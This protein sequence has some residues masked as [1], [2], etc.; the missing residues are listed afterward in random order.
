VRWLIVFAA[1]L[2]AALG[3]A[4]WTAASLAREP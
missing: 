4:A 1:T 2:V 3:C